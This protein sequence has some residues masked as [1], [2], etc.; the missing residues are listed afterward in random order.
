MRWT[1][2]VERDVAEGYRFVMVQIGVLLTIEGSI[3]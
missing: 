2:T 1:D 3:M